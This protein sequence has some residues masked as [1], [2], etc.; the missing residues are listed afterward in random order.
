MALVDTNPA[1]NIAPNPPLQVGVSGSTLTLGWPTNL[2]WILQSQTN[3]SAVGLTPA[4][5]WFDV[6]G[7][8]AQTDLVITMSP[9]NPAVFYRLR[10]PTAPP[11]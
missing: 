10:Y 3:A 1:I 8:A 6:A 4:T 2:G 7:T 5:N 11:Q 9:T